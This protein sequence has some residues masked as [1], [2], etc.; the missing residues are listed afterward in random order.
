MSKDKGMKVTKGPGGKEVKVSAAVKHVNVQRGL[1]TKL[2]NLNVGSKETVDGIEVTYL[3]EE[4][5]LNA[6]SNLGYN[7]RNM[8]VQMMMENYLAIRTPPGEQEQATYYLCPTKK[9]GSH[10]KPKP[11][12][13]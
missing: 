1:I 4:Q 8:I 3:Y 10:L 6:I 9:I 12:V 7:G 5:L 11:K 13:A 2:I